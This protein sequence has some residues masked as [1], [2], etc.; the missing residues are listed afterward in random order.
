MTERDA[1]EVRFHA[2]VRGYAGRVSSDLDPVE[3]AHRIAAAEPRRHGLAA[4]LEWRTVAIPRVAWL[5]LLLGA[6]LAALVGGMLLAGSQEQRRLPAILPPVGQ[7]FACPPG[8]TPDRPGPVDQARPIGLAPTGAALAFDR[9][10]GRLVA[11]TTAGGRVET[12][13]FDVCTNT[14]TQMHPNR[15]PPGGG[16]LVYDI[17]FDV[18]ILVSSESAWSS[19]PGENHVSV[20]QAVSSRVWAY[21]LQAD[22]WTEKGDAPTD[23]ALR[24]YDPFSGLVVATSNEELWSYDVD[25]DTWT[26]IHE[27]NQSGSFGAL[28][29]DPSVDRMVAYTGFNA[30]HE[31]WLLDIRTGR[32]SKSNAVT[33][34]VLDWLTLPAIAYD[35]AAERTVVGGNVRLAAY[36]AT[37]DRW[38]TV[39]FPGPDPWHGV[40]LVYDPVNE[41]L[42]VLPDSWESW[43][44]GSS[45][46]VVALDLVTREWTVLLEPGPG[47]ATP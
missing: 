39:E 1:F 8:S 10:A 16:P 47:Q 43:S 6:L 21:N 46:G 37:A 26:P 23:S 28:A 30:G 40:S 5:L 42:V 44:V 27:A 15:E 11:L 38:E 12:W 13:T 24:T 3:L 4:A 18:S 32:W 20:P 33:P 22:T 41:R 45:A 14:W 36:D 17:D 29:Y 9:R 2:A 19:P 34:H 7:V 31:T 35:E 25:T